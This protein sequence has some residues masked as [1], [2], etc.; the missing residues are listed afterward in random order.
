M[1]RAL[2]DVQEAI[3][4]LEKNLITCVP[5]CCFGHDNKK[6]IAAMIDVLKNNRTI[7]WINSNFLTPTE[8]FHEYPDNPLWRAALD[9]REWLDGSFDVNDL[10][11]NDVNTFKK[12]LLE[13]LLF[14]Q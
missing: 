13:G 7:V 14:N 5:Y 6:R 9:A 12:G 2:K 10:L 11:F 3:L 8:L 4:K 1:Q